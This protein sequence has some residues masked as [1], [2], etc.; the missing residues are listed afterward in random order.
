MRIMEIYGETNTT[1]L[2]VVSMAKDI[3]MTVVMVERK[4]MEAQVS[5]LAMNLALELK[6]V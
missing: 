3:C 2:K 5:A 1:I 4:N 6:M